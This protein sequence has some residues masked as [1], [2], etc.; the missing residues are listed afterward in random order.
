MSKGKD[1]DGEEERANMEGSDREE[2]VTVDI[3]GRIKDP[4]LELHF[5]GASWVNSLQ[6]PLAKSGCCETQ[7]KSE[8][9]SSY[10]SSRIGSSSVA[11]PQD[12]DYTP[13]LSDELEALILARV[14]RS[15]YWKFSTVCKRFLSL[16]KS[17]EIFKIRREIGFKEP[18]VFMLASGETSWWAFDP[19]SES[20]R[21]LPIL[22]SDSCFS[23]GDKE[24]LC[25][26]THLMVSGKE[27]DGLVI[28][29]YELTENKWFKGDSMKNPRCL[30]ASATCGNYAFVA[31]GIGIGSKKEVLNSAEK[32]DPQT[33][34]WDRL[35][36]MHQRRKMCSGCYMDNK[37]F[38][39]GGKNEEEKNLTCAEAFDESQNKWE[40]I[41]G[42]LKDMPVST[43]HSPPLLAVV[44]NE[45]YTLETSSNE[46]KVYIKSSNSWKRLGPVPIR[47]DFNGGW[48]IAFKSLGSELL[49][50]GASSASYS[51]HGMTIFTCCPDPDTEELQWTPHGCAKN[52]SS[53]FILNCCVMMA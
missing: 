46:L 53:H 14:P 47:A 22:P 40:I 10:S 23:A 36:V 13:S 44:N 5:C 52:S 1:L 20:C 51:S 32:Y 12:A 3:D 42:M 7:R 15:L 43:V 27:I 19:H 18:A 9:R 31:G 49:V 38:V 37:F 2:E 39:I 26:G 11:E 28:Y 8:K 25:A 30:F 17:G 4:V 48:G 34:S 35:P 41:P 50:I 24:T 29:R 16:I 45:L 6:C 21:N 33:K